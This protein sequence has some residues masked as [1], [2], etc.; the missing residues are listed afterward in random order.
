MYTVYM[1]V[2]VCTYV[3]MYVCTYMY[4]CVYV[5][6]YMCVYNIS[7]NIYTHKKILIGA[8][9]I[10]VITTASYEYKTRFQLSINFNN[11]S[12]IRQ[13]FFIG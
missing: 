3:C 11:V 9:N 8:V 10:I 2:C 1:Y 7:Y 5:C 4:V 12:Q 6:M 13:T